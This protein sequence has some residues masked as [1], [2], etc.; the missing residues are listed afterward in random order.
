ME[1]FG[2]SIVLFKRVVYFSLVIVV[3]AFFRFLRGLWYIFRTG[4]R[5]SGS[6]FMKLILS[7]RSF[8][9]LLVFMEFLGFLMKKERWLVLGV[10]LVFIN[11]LLLVFRVFR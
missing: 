2:F 11:L 9:G 1:D 4:I 10:G 7:V 6:F 3:V 5:G 8:K